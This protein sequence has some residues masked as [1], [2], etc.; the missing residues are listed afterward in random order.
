MLLEV[1]KVISPWRVGRRLKRGHEGDI[2]AADNVWFFDLGVGYMGMC[3]IQKFIKA[4]H[5]Y[6]IC[7]F[8]VNYASTKDP[9]K[10]KNLTIVDTTEGK[11]LCYGFYCWLPM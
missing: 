7:T 2:L 1:R 10:K 9:K 5:L 11:P 8:Y 4:V 6:I 3:N